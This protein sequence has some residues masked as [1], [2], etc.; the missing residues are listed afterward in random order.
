MAARKHVDLSNEE[1]THRADPE[2]DRVDLELT[3]R[4]LRLRSTLRKGSPIA[5]AVQCLLLMVVVFAPPAAAGALMMWMGFG[6]VGIA[7][8]AGVVLLVAVGLMIFVY[9]KTGADTDGPAPTRRPPAQR[10][11]D[12][13][14]RNRSR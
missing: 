9:K 8:T 1:T 5:A 10:S 11:K 4:G 12:N 3:S 13:R 14:R 2:I 7:V 6:P